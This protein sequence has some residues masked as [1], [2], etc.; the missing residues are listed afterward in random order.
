MTDVTPPV[1]SQRRPGA[2]QVT[3]NQVSQVQGAAICNSDS[4]NRHI[5][6]AGSNRDSRLGVTTAQPISEARGGIC[7]CQKRNRRV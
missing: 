4:V 5:S 2:A 1:P 3:G 7:L 6:P